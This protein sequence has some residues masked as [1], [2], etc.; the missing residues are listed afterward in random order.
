[1][2]NEAPAAN[3]S[4]VWTI[5]A[6]RMKAPIAHRVPLSRRA[7]KILRDLEHDGKSGDY[8]FVGQ[9]EGHYRTWACDDAAPDETG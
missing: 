9:R 3:I 6:T 8:V 4:N 7:M 1:M 5:P 2:W